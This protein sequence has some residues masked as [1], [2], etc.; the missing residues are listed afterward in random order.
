MVWGT[1]HIITLDKPIT[2]NAGEKL[3]KVK[4]N[5]KVNGTAMNLKYTDAE[6]LV[7]TAENL[8]T[9]T[10]NLEIEGKDGKIDNIAYV[11]D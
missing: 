8:D 7:Y 1:P 11:I 9:D 3:K 4:F 5:P 10:A 2:V 6:K